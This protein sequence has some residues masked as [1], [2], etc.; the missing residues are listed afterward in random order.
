MIVLRL[1]SIIIVTLALTGCPEYQK[2]SIAARILDIKPQCKPPSFVSNHQCR[3]LLKVTNIKDNRARA[4]IAMEAV[5]TNQKGCQEL[6]AEEYYPPD[7][8]CPD[9]KNYPDHDYE[10]QIDS[11]TPI[12]GPG[13]YTFVNVPGTPF[14]KLVT[15]VSSVEKA[16]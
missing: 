7:Y 16:Q 2:R 11:S 12:E 6:I 14:L 10:I 3:Y 15:S 8:Y 9:P 13:T 5:E 1:F 4:K